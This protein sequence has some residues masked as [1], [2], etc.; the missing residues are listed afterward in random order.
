MKLF[1]AAWRAKAHQAEATSLL[2]G[3]SMQVELAV[4]TWNFIPLRQCPPVMSSTGGHRRK[5]DIM[6]KDELLSVSYRQGCALTA[7]RLIVAHRAFG[8]PDDDGDVA[9]S[10]ESQ[11]SSSS[12]SLPAETIPVQAGA[13]KLFDINLT[14]ATHAPREKVPRDRTAYS[15]P[16]QHSY[17]L[18]GRDKFPPGPVA[19]GF[20][21]LQSKNMGELCQFLAI[22]PE[23]QGGGVPEV[24]VWCPLQAGM[25]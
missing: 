3:I 25:W 18:T 23:R 1:P 13:R 10:A 17:M 21:G 16:V 22:A 4:E 8:R 6:R 24:A 5:Q 11:A 2:T 19:L 9:T 15:W 20:D 14:L 12:E 7:S